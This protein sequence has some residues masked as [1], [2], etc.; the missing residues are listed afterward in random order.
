MK[1]KITRYGIAYYHCPDCEARLNY[2][3][4]NLKKDMS[5]DRRNKDGVGAYCKKHRRIRQARYNSA[6][7]NEKRKI[8][9]RVSNER[10][11]HFKG[12]KRKVFDEPTCVVVR[13][14]GVCKNWG[15]VGYERRADG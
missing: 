8:G 14:Y 10:K 13:Y 7:K 12:K 9:Y 2:D 5:R 6:R 11:W 15:K 1:K 3:A 4:Y